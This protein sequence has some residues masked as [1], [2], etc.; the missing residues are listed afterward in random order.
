MNDLELHD[1]YNVFIFLP[2]DELTAEQKPKMHSW[3]MKE[4]M[5][6]QGK[7]YFFNTLG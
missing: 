2:F 7:K 5:I 4:K 3:A 1:T 6:K